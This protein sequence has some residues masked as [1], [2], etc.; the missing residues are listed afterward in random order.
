MQSKCSHK[1][2]IYW[3][4]CTLKIYKESPRPLFKAYSLTVSSLSRDLILFLCSNIVGG[5]ERLKIGF[6]RSQTLSNF[7]IISHNCLQFTNQFSVFS[8]FG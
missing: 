4:Y 5:W 1:V 3:Y 2:L 6:S 8:D 7:L